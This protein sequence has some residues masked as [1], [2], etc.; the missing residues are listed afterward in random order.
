MQAFFALNLDN[1]QTF[2]DDVSTKTAVQFDA[3]IDQRHRLLPLELKAKA[4]NS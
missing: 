2:D 4:F 1:Y 3:V